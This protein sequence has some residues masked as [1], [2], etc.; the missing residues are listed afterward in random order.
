MFGKNRK[1]KVGLCVMVVTASLVLAGL[2]A[3]LATPETA[4]AVKPE[5]PPKLPK[6]G[7]GNGKTVYSVDAVDHGGPILNPDG[8]H[9]YNSPTLVSTC[10]GSAKA[11]GYVAWP[12][13]EGCMNI[14]PLGSAYELTDD[15]ILRVLYERKKIVAVRFRIQD[16]DG[17]EGI[18]HETENIMIDPIDPPGNHNSEPFILHVHQD[19][20]PVWRLDGHT[21]GPRVEVIGTI[22]VGD[23]VFTPE[24]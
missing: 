20:V 8:T 18:Q 24:P 11:V 3:V 9:R 5:K 21:G 17:A 10:P 13:H 23:I 19:D 6:D 14:T 2:W 15:P 7:G 12:R 16:V 22:S 4:L 1:K